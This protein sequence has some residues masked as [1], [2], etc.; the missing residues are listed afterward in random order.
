MPKEIYLDNNATTKCGPKVVEKNVAV[1][2]SAVKNN[3]NKKHC[4]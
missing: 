4:L 2:M 3:P 1:I